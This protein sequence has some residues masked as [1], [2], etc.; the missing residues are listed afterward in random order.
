MKA[1][2]IV[3]GLAL[4]LAAA[5]IEGDAWYDAQGELVRVD[6]P[7]AESAP[8]PFVPEWK[9]REWA[10]LE[11]QR[12]FQWDGGYFGSYRDWGYRFHGG[13]RLYGPRVY[14]S[15]APCGYRVVRSYRAPVRRG[16]SVIIRR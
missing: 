7:A 13:Y 8:R 3:I 10:R 11:R 16:V 1:L 2:W 6:G 12:G 15:Y 4:P 14:R 9:Q 5:E